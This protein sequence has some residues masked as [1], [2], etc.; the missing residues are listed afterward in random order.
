MSNHHSFEISHSLVPTCPV[1]LTPDQ[2]S[3]PIANDTAPNRDVRIF[4]QPRI[5][6]GRECVRKQ[7]KILPK[8]EGSHA[9]IQLARAHRL[10]C[11]SEQRVGAEGEI[12][13][14]IHFL[15]RQD[16]LPFLISARPRCTCRVSV[17]TTI[18]CSQQKGTCFRTVVFFR[19]S[20][21]AFRGGV[22]VRNRRV[23]PVVGGVSR[24]C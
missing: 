23:G 14:N 5:S 19:P 13:Q 17:V 16:A 24:R 11:E 3:F 20:Y 9:C 4:S 6:S 15:H 10:P 2:N 7:S 1:S 22:G 8:R 12:K 21:S 18:S